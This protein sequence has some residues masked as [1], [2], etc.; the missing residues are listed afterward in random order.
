M[1]LKFKRRKRTKS[2]P[3]KP[4]RRRARRNPA[5][6]ARVRTRTR[7]VVK[8][9]TRRE[10]TN[11]KRSRR[12]TR[13]NPSGRGI[14]AS[15]RNG[16]PYIL[17]IGGGV[18]VGLFGVRYIPSMIPTRFRGLVPALLGIVVASMSRNAG[19]RNFGYGLGGAGVVDLVR[20]NIPAFALA[21]I[22]TLQE[23][24]ALQGDIYTLNGG[25]SFVNTLGENSGVSDQM[26]Q[27]VPSLGDFDTM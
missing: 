11:P 18:V 5:K 1:A 9:R 22:T 23:I 3:T 13:R 27:S 8:Y 14:W 21:E 16:A 2:N 26:Y 19:L 20:N 15:I 4:R 7:T 25:E 17:G 6:A 24:P 10:K 12:R